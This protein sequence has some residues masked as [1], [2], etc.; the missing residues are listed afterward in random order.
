MAGLLVI[1]TLFA[2]DSK[3][4]V[5]VGDTFNWISTVGVC[6]CFRFTKQKL[7]A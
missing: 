3:R 2:E 5:C 1:F 6:S 7:F 4:N